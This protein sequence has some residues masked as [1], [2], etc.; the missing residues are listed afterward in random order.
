[1]ASVDAC[2]LVESSLRFVVS[3]IDGRRPDND[4]SEVEIGRST[5]ASGGTV[6]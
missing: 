3:G 4:S 5:I 6:A 2:G 1:M